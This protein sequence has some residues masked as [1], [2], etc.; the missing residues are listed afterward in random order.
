M[1]KIEHEGVKLECAYAVPGLTLQ[2]LCRI[3]HDARDAAGPHDYLSGNPCKWPDT[4][5]VIAVTDAILDAIY[6]K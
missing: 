1:H 4:R 6:G 5:G 3:F 2:D